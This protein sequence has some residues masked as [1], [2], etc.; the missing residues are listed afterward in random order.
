MRE[1]YRMAKIRVQL[2]EGSDHLRHAVDLLLGLHEDFELV[3]DDSADVVLVDLRRP[4]GRTFGVLRHRAVSGPVVA[5][6][7]DDIQARAAVAH[8]AR[9]AVVKADGAGVFLA[10]VRRVALGGEPAVAA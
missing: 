2:L 3:G 4:L 6:A 10:A 9:E 5:L 8:G 1:R 7:R